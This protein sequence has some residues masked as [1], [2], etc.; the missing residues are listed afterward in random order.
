M[1]WINWK[2]YLSRCNKL[3]W[4]SFILGKRFA[5]EKV[6]KPQCMILQYSTYPNILIISYR[7][8][9]IVILSYC[10]LSDVIWRIVIKL[11][12]SFSVSVSLKE[13]YSHTSFHA[14][15]K[16][17]CFIKNAQSISLS[18]CVVPQSIFTVP[19]SQD[20]LEGSRDDFSV[21]LW[22][23]CWNYN[24]KWHHLCWVTSNFKESQ[25]QKLESY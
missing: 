21:E 6:K 18:F 25:A 22:H 17:L 20:L 19:L 5:V 2:L 3:C 4:Q 16:T 13:D 9:S 14:L 7:D 12:R 8:W 15:S 23:D 10:D 24:E 1:R 11:Y